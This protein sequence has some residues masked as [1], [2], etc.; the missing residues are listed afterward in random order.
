MACGAARPIADLIEPMAAAMGFQ[1]I[2]VVLGGG[3]GRRLQVMAERADGSMSVEDCAVLS[4]NLSAFLDEKDPIEGSYALE[5]SS[6]GIRRPLSRWEDFHRWSG[7]VARIELSNPIDGR[8]RF[9]GRLKGVEEQCVAIKVDDGL[10]SIP[11]Q[12]IT[13]ACLLEETPE[14]KSA[15]GE[16]T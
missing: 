10:V 12:D 3:A 5:V 13:R 11:A 2:R 9:R 1:I 4:R 7:H 16:G 15:P 8:K 14:E 6:P